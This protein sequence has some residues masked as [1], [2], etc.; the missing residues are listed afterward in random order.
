MAQ[1]QKRQPKGTPKGGEFAQEHKPDGADLSSLDFRHISVRISTLHH[2]D[3]RGAMA[4]K[5]DMQG[6]ELDGCNLSGVDFTR[7][8]L[9]RTRFVD[10]DLSNTTFF[11]T[12]VAGT[13]FRGAKITNANFTGVRD[14][15]KAKGLDQLSPDSGPP[16][17]LPEGWEYR[18][19]GIFKVGESNG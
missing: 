7:S 6:G 1:T 3:L 17:E 19:H 13:E 12:R 5:A 8:N 16:A 4:R 18:E 2:R 15:D 10:A 14:L 9:E 11:K